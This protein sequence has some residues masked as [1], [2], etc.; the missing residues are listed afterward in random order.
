VDSD[1]SHPKIII[2]DNR[3]DNQNK[4]SFEDKKGELD[5]TGVDKLHGKT[6]RDVMILLKD[7]SLQAHTQARENITSVQELVELDKKDMEIDNMELNLSRIDAGEGRV[8]MA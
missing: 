5:N 8:E 2:E 4:P 6:M 7:G 1:V 3:S